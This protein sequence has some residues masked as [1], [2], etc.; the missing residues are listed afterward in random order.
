MLNLVSGATG[1]LGSYVVAELLKRKQK[2]IACRQATSNTEALQKVLAL[3]FEDW[4]QAYQK[5]EWRELDITNLL[6]VEL[7]LEGVDRVYHCAGQVSFA[8]SSH[9]KLKSINE[10][11][12]A[13]LVNVCL[14]KPTI[15]LCHVSSISTL[16]NSEHMGELDERVFWKSTGR[17]SG[18][19]LSKY[20]AEREV[21]RGIEEGL[22]A[23][24]VN[25]GIILAPAFWQHSSARLVNLSFKGNRF[26]TDGF[27]GYVMVDDVAK[28]MVDL[29]EKKVS[30]ERFVVIENNYSYFEI[31]SMFHKG[32][33]HTSSLK[34]LPLRLLKVASFFE[35]VFSF[36]IG[37]DVFLTPSF[38]KSAFNQQLFSGQ[39][40]KNLLNYQ[41]IPVPQGISEICEIYLK[42]QRSLSS[43]TEALKA[44]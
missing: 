35:R 21:W 37:R 19:A 1:I 20:N 40:L 30:A 27:S 14:T 8:S 25:P 16:N 10:D 41:F 15:Q 34:S 39:K 6:S 4:E 33:K 22:Q 9:A 7:A 31:F 44:Q 38:L 24:I 42:E 29:S 26:Y 11:G 2:V 43:K 13:N 28:V 3:K 36:L 12:T 18:Y 5:I 32:F 17:E 23:V